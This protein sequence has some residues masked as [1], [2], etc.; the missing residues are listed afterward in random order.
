MIDYDP[1]KDAENIQKHGYP[2]AAAEFLFEG[3]FVEEEDN[4]RNYGESRFVATG[5]VAILGNRLCVAVYTWRNGVRRVISFRKAND[6]E[7]RQYQASVAG[8]R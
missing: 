5:P 2:L 3:E 1:M 8:R 7:V 6:R 4:R